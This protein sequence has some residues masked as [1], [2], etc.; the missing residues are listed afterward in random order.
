MIAY[1]DTSAL[2]K[3]V[4][5]ESGAELADDVWDT[6]DVV[7]SSDLA[8]PEARCATAA[9]HRG[10][11]LTESELRQATSHI[12]RFCNSMELLKLDGIVGRSA[13]VLGERHGLRGGDAVHLATV[14]GVPVRRV[15]MI[16]W[17]RDLARAATANGIG[18]IPARQ[19]PIQPGEPVV[20]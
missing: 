19:R 3:R 12:D 14:A 8:Y 16:T 17:D 6:A 7:L 15:V 2:M 10:G 4:F 9:A 20:R 18:V 1:F 13:G 11:R 5:R